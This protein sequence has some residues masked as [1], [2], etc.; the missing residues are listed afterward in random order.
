MG[1]SIK[2]F[3]YKGVCSFKDTKEEAAEETSLLHTRR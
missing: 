2:P 3:K 1:I